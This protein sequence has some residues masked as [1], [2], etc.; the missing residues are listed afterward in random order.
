MANKYASLPEEDRKL[1]KFYAQLK[2]LI[3]AEIQTKLEKFEKKLEAVV[4]S[5]NEYNRFCN[6]QFY[7]LLKDGVLP[8]DLYEMNDSVQMTLYGLQRLHRDFAYSHKKNQYEFSAQENLKN[9]EL[10]EL[11]EI[12]KGLMKQLYD[13]KN[14]SD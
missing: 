8:D 4:E 5:F 10:T 9:L 6:H 12:I 14:P 11:R 1:T 7:Y 3:D 13:K 2:K